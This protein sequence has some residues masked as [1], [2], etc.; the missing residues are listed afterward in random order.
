M[1]T[2]AL[3]VALLLVVT[4]LLALGAIAYLVHRYPRLGTP[5]MVCGTFAAAYVAAVAVIV[6]TARG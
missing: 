3:L 1:S 6:T 2:L 4:G 5:L